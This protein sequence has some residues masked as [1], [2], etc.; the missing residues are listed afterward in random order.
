MGSL[1]GAERF[2]IDHKGRVAI[3]AK[4]RRALAPDARDSFV[5][6][7]GFDGC[8]YLYPLDEWQRYEEK[9]RN[10]S[11]G[12]AKARRFCRLLLDNAS[13]VQVDGQGRVV[14]PSVLLTFA[15]L[16]KEAKILGLVDH[17]EIW[18]PDRFAQA[19]GGAAGGESLEDLAKEYLK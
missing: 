9:L 12:D 16:K 1:Y 17:I 7:P 11:P 5:L 10:L 14:L 18:D 13:E 6:V 19:T 15:G 4:L 8:L 3:P 2:A